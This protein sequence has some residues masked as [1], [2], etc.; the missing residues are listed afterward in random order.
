MWISVYEG[1]K[2]VEGEDSTVL[3]SYLADAADSFIT[4]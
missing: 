1:A 3:P 2:N 4:S